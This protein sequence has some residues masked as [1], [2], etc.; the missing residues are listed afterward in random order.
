MLRLKTLCCLLTLSAVLLGAPV[1]RSADAGIPETI[2]IDQLSGRYGKVFFDH[3]L[4]DSY[5]ACS[6]CHHHVAGSPPSNPACT[7]CHR[8][9]KAGRPGSCKSCH[10]ASRAASLS[11]AAEEPSRRYHIDI[12]GLSGAYHLRCVN[13]HLA[14]TA[15][16]TGC[17][18]C[19]N[20]NGEPGSP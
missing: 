15:G 13:C 3:G 14:I 5:A 17:L 7:P 6:V 9:G 10:P 8:Q 18:G 2:V 20:L 11:A 4:H 19:H 12:P 1:A 16:P